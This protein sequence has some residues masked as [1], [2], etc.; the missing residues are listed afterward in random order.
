MNKNSTLNLA[1]HGYGYLIV[2]ASSLQSIFLL[3]IRLHWG[4][5]FFITGKGKLGDIDKV[6]G[7]F[8][9]LG[10]P[11]PT[12]NAYLS[13]TT[14]CLGGLCLLFGIASR[15]TTIPL[16][17][18]MIIAYLTAE[19]EALQ[20]LF[21]DPDKFTGADPFLFMLTAII[22]FLFGPGWISVDGLLKRIF[23][24]KKTDAHASPVAVA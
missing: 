14:E 16:I 19:H 10:I 20:S 1:R 2:G 9:S 7:F 6:T 12:L 24:E 3:V 8:Q 23:V 17:F 4:W 11:F 21:S 22:V 5:Q 15:L 13:G 18:T